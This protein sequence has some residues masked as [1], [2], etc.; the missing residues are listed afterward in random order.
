MSVRA[1]CRAV[2]GAQF[3]VDFLLV[4]VGQEWVESRLV[5]IGAFAFADLVRRQQ[6]GQALLPVGV[7]GFDFAFGLGRGPDA[8]EMGF[9]VCVRCSSVRLKS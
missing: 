3:A 4:D 7:A 6:C 5:G 9:Q 1:C 8:G 2:G